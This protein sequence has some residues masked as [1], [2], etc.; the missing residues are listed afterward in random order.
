MEYHAGTCKDS[1]LGPHKDF[2][3]SPRKDFH[4]G[5]GS[6]E[7]STLPLGVRGEHSAQLSSASAP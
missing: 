2:H 1:T 4:A 5:I 7:F 3:L 6:Q